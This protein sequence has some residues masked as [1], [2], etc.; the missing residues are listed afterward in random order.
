M[1]KIIWYCEISY[2]C[3]HGSINRSYFGLLVVIHLNFVEDYYVSIGN[4][5]I[6]TF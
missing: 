2:F 1:E 6:F 5:S 3:N 4:N